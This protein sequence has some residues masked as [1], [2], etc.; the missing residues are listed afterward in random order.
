MA[1]V[2]GAGAP[3]LSMDQLKQAVANHLLEPIGTKLSVNDASAQ[4]W[5]QQ[6]GGGGGIDANGA[7]RLF[8]VLLQERYAHWFPT[9]LP[10]KA[11]NF[12]RRNTARVE[13]IYE[14]GKLL[15]EGSFGKVYEVTHKVSGEKR[16]CKKILKQRGREGM[17][18]EE[19]IQEIESMAQ[20]DHP[21]V[22][23]VYEYF[24]DRDSVAQIMEPCRGGELQG[25]IDEVFQKGKPRY[26]EEFICDVMKQTLR[27]LAFMHG[28]KFMHKDLKPQNIMLV[29]KESSSIKVID[30][31]LAELFQKDQKVSETF[32]GTLLYMAPEVFECKLTFKVDIW[33]AGVIL[34][35]L[36]CGDYPF[37]ATWPLP[38]GKDMNWWQNELSRSIQQDPYRQNR[39]LTDGSVSPACLD[40]LHK[41]LTKDVRIRPDAAGCLHHPWFKQFEATP[42]PLSVG[43]VQCLEAFSMQPELK[44]AVFLLIAHQCSAPALQELRA[45]FTHFDESNRGSLSTNNF[46]DVLIRSGMTPLQVERIIHA[47]D[48]DDSGTV[49][50]TEFIAA[51]LC[52]SVCNNPKLVGAAFSIFDQDHDDKVS[53]QDFANVFAHGECRAVWHRHLPEECKQIGDVGPDMKYS[54]DQFRKYMGGRMTVTSGDGLFA[55]E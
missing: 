37:M 18:L 8:K 17:K 36:I 39:R 3:G 32:G 10:A 40:L 31:G 29:D 28:E 43:M 49:E 54:K 22:I 47:L 52:I 13:D 35:N 5:V 45:I 12:V 15:G 55:V 44:K 38:P 53:A 46:Q 9:K 16:V 50:W 51:A 11:H 25:T 41:M 48:K 42:P 26:T 24:E 27:A 2:A 7:V 19:I 33:S 23:K 34:Y 21:N 30:F 14:V 6:F 20:L 1:S 4:R